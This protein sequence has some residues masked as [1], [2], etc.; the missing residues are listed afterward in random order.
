MCCI[1]FRTHYW[2]MSRPPRPVESRTDDI[3]Y[4]FPTEPARLV[5]GADDARIMVPWKTTDG[6]LFGVRG[7]FV[8]SLF[9][10]T[11]L[12]VCDVVEDDGGAGA[13]SR[14]LKRDRRG[15]WPITG[16][17]VSQC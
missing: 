7:G 16:E 5:Q 11:V 8:F 12:R 10:E 2:G 4:V 1:P 15:Y 9:E 17:C 3:V 14:S 13:R 6:D